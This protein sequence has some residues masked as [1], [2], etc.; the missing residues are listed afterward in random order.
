MNSI[1]PPLLGLSQRH[2]PSNDRAEMALLGALLANNKAY[3]RVSEF[4]AEHHFADPIHGRIYRAIQRRLEAGQ[5]PLPAADR[6]P[7]PQP[8]R[9][10]RRS[11]TTARPTPACRRPT[12]LRLPRWSLG[13]DASLPGPLGSSCSDYSF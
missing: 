4:L 5:Q 9:A 1:D 6:I 12:S 10:F 8:G 7:D 13:E 3:E 2:P 11:S